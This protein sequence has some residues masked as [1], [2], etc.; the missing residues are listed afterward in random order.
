[1]ND[2]FPQRIDFA[3]A[4]DIIARV[5]AG[6]RLP[7]APVALARAHAGVLADP[8][9]ATAPLPPFYNASM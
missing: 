9:D 1:M 2:D 5:T 3:Q 4:R 8:D 6:R 7:A